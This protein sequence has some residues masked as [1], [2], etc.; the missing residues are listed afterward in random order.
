MATLTARGVQ[1][2]RLLPAWLWPDPSD[3]GVEHAKVARI[4]LGLVFCYLAMMF[5]PDTVYSYARFVIHPLGILWVGLAM[6][7][8]TRRI[9]FAFP[10]VLLLLLQVWMV[11]S[12][13]CAEQFIPK[14]LTTGQYLWYPIEIGMVYLVTLVL[15]KLMPGAMRYVINWLLVLC[16]VSA[17]MAILQAA[18]FGPA[19]RI[20]DYYVYR[21]I[22]NWD[23]VA[24]IRA[25][26][27]NAESNANLLV[28][29][30]GA[31]LLAYKSTKRSLRPFEWTMWGMFIVGSFTG[32]HRSSMPLV[33]LTF[34]VTLAVMMRNRPVA[35]FGVLAGTAALFLLAFTAGKHNF[36]YTFETTWSMETP[37]LKGRIDESKQAYALFLKHPIT[38]IG[39]AP[40]AEAF[41]FR[42]TEYD[43]KVENL[44][45][46]TLM[47][48]GVPGLTIVLTL[49]VGALAICLALYANRR[50]T[51]PTRILALVGALA[52]FNLLWNGNVRVNL[53]TMHNIFAYL[54][55]MAIVQIRLTEGSG[56]QRRIR[57]SPYLQ[58]RDPAASL[59]QN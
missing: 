24:G 34:L 26:G 7:K 13:V 14:P 49:Y 10:F 42:S 39:P 41:G 36:A 47:T 1:P 15:G 52:A 3:R 59:V 32:Q 2:K 50:L 20:A 18:H 31:G 23:R 58:N 28:L 19:I 12:M 16:T 9:R 30:L 8:M 40:M 43:F 38:G 57:V 25:S 11:I 56:V 46:S 6:T 51:Y 45:Y 44:Y 29:L 48:L 5:L 22:D 27:L 4:G 37:E 55:L 17:A 33:G 21:S 53:G 54:A 35:F